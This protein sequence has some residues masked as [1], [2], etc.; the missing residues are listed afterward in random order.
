MNKYYIEKLTPIKELAWQEP[1]VETLGWETIENLVLN[2]VFAARQHIT[3]KGDLRLS[4]RITD[5]GR[6][7]PG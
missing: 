6:Y 2:T 3:Q 7:W 4:Y 1:N 5:G